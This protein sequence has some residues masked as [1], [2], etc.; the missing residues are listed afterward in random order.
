MIWNFSSQNGQVSNAK[1]M[2]IAKNIQNIMADNFVINQND[3]FWRYN[4]NELV[5]KGAHFS[6]YFLLGSIACFLANVLFRRVW[7]ATAIS[8]IICPIYAYIDE[9]R[10]NFE[11]GRNPRWFDWKMDVAGAVFGIVMATI[12][13]LIFRY[14]HKLKARINELEDR[15]D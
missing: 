5:R 13:F 3:Y 2:F 7:L 1:S 10:Q 9:Y 4:M 14:I 15:H 12:V 8:L 11:P 6:E